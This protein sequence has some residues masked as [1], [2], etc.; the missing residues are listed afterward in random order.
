MEE[1]INALILGHQNLHYEV[2]SVK[3]TSPVFHRIKLWKSMADEGGDLRQIVRSYSR[4]EKRLV[5][6]AEATTFD[7]NL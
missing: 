4:G 6:I 2:G 1:R 7:I 3:T 5:S